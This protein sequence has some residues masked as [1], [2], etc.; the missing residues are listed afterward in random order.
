MNDPWNRFN[1]L[2]TSSTEP[3]LDLPDIIPPALLLEK[4]TSKSRDM[5]IEDWYYAN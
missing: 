3:K 5:S 2:W 1:P 4:E